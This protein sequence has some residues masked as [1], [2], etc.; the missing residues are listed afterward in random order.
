MFHVEH[1]ARDHPLASFLL[2]KEGGNPVLL[3][4]L[5]S[6]VINPKLDQLNKPDQ[7]D[8][9]DEPDKLNKPKGPD[10]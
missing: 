9:L 8:K 6:L 1:S 5:V 3:V 7:R 4:Y 10:F 2:I